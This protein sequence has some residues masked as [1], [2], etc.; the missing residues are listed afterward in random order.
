MAAAAVDCHATH[1]AS[2]RG[3]L[4]LAQPGRLLAAEAV[5]TAAAVLPAD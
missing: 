1:A 5:I 3:P 2:W 4:S